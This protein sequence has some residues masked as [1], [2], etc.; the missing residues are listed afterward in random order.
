MK[1]DT[2][3]LVVG[4]EEMDVEEGMAEGEGEG[5]GGGEGEGEIRTWKGRLDGRKGQNSGSAG[6]KVSNQ[7][8]RRMLDAVQ[9]RYQEEDVLSNVEC[10]KKGW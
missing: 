8:A 3:A 10:L 6:S 2:Y 5:E 4:V 7:S 9:D 1:I